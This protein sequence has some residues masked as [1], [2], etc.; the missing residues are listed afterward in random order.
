MSGQRLQCDVCGWQC[1]GEKGMELED[2]HTHCPGLKVVVVQMALLDAAGKILSDLGIE[3]DLDRG[4]IVV[5]YGPRLVQPEQLID[6]ARAVKAARML[7]VGLTHGLV[8]RE[9][10][11]VFVAKMKEHFGITVS[12]RYMS[13]RFR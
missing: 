9:D 12:K 3:I 1:E 5:P 6:L 10:W 13:K 2:A 11:D 7:D 4:V 8:T